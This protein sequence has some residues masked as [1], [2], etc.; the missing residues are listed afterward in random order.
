MVQ[1]TGLGIA[2]IEALAFNINQL[3]GIGVGTLFSIIGVIFVIIQMIIKH[4]EFKLREVIQL[5]F[6]VI[7]GL[8]VD[9]VIYFVFPNDL[10]LSTSLKWILFAFGQTIS[11]LGIGLFVASGVI[12]A[13]LECLCMTVSHS[14]KLQ[15]KHARWIVEGIVLIIALLLFIFGDLAISNIGLGTILILIASGPIIQSL[16]EY[17]SRMYARFNV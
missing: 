16:I 12:V 9:L 14:Y 1:K 13:P 8:F 7:Y 3:T 15:F 2:P 10:Q 11:Y 17:F 6:M 5:L 4:K